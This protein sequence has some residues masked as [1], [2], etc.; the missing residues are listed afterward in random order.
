MGR[1]LQS[2]AN[3]IQ[4]RAIAAGR[5]TRGSS[6]ASMADIQNHGKAGKRKTKGQQ[7]AEY[8]S[9]QIRYDDNNYMI[10]YR[11][12]NEHLHIGNVYNYGSLMPQQCMTNTTLKSKII[13]DNNLKILLAHKLLITLRVE[14]AQAQG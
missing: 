5:S 7:H 6:R 2:K 11:F 13:R 14:Q 4:N 12:E 3:R 8:Y 10:E 1:G 9:K